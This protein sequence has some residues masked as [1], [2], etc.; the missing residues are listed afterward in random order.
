MKAFKINSNNNKIIILIIHPNNNKTLST[1]SQTTATTTSPTCNNSQTTTTTIIIKVKKMHPST[2]NFN[3][4]KTPVTTKYNNQTIFRIKLFRTKITSK[5]YR[6]P[7][8]FNTKNLPYN[9]III[10]TTIISNKINPSNTTTIITLDCYKPLRTPKITPP[11]KAVLLFN[12][13]N[14]KITNNNKIII[15]KIIM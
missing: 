2:N 3:K 12:N 4:A 6:K 5:N 10:I 14:N 15:I 1:T 13:N 11:N 9:T 7:N 8:P